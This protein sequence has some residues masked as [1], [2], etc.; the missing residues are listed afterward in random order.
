MSSST[1]EPQKLFDRIAIMGVGL[2]GGSI[3]L[4]AKSWNVAD[5][6]IG[7]GR[8]RSRLQAAL[9][10][11][12]IEEVASTPE[13]LAKAD[14]IVVCTPVDRIAEDAILALRATSG[15]SILI[16]DAGSVKTRILEEIAHQVSD[17]RFVGA[18]P[19]AGSHHSGFEHAAPNLFQSRLCLVTP[20]SDQESG[21]ESENKTKQV[22]RFWEQ[23]GMRVKLMSAEEHD[24]I[25]AL[26][27]HLPHLAASVVAGIVDPAFLE[28]AATGYRDTT[29]VAAGD[30]ELWSAILTM[31]SPEIIN[32]IDQMISSLQQYREHL[33]E[34]QKSAV[35]SLLEQGKLNR[36]CYREETP[37]LDDGT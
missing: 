14:L 13:E 3:A 1:S 23:I 4:A 26:T 12:I 37:R 8:N 30:P 9:E 18:H 19:L 7:Y 28:Y 29:R 36:Q 25:L 34:N 17:D 16:T 20:R 31:N 24:R 11:G 32:G 5:H 10:R 27:S 2:I 6:V 21:Q 15:S 33:Q 22:C 35:V